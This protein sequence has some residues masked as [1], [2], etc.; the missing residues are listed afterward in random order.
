MLCGGFAQSAFMMKPAF[1]NGKAGFFHDAAAFNRYVRTEP[2][3]I[4]Q[5]WAS[6]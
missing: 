5:P 6:D 2:A 4:V 1:P 3:L